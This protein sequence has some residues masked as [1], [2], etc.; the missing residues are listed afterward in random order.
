VSKCPTPSYKLEVLRTK[1]QLP[2]SYLQPSRS[3]VLTFKANGSTPTSNIHSKIYIYKWEKQTWEVRKWNMKNEFNK[4]WGTQVRMWETQILTFK[5]QLLISKFQLSNSK[6]NESTITLTTN[7][8]TCKWKMY[9]KSEKMIIG[10]NERW[11]TQ[12]KRHK[13]QVLSF[14]LKITYVGRVIFT[15]Y[16][17]NS[18]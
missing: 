2:T 10:F 3:K 6:T 5:V 14:F 17:L 16:Q 18:H 13:T 11:E 9:V 15:Q 7:H 1:L 12:V 8:I 4:R